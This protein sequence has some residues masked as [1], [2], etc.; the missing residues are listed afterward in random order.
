MKKTALYTIPQENEANYYWLEVLCGNCGLKS[1]LAFE[2]HLR[3]SYH[4]CPKCGLEEL[5][6]VNVT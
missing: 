3:V 4:S 6:K 2:K 5:E 1:S